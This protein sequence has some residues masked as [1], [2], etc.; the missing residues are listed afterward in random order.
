MSVVSKLFTPR[1]VKLSEKVLPSGTKITKL[2][3]GKD[4]ITRCVLSA[5]N[6]AAQNLG[7]QQIEKRITSDGKEVISSVIQNSHGDKLVLSKNEFEELMFYK[8]RHPLW[9]INQLFN[10]IKLSSIA[11]DYIKKGHL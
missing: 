2:V 10:K 6:K 5:N 3:Q 1:V 8:K 7:L 11:D 4:K 9:S